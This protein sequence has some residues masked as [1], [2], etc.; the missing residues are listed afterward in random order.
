MTNDDVYMRQWLS[1]SMGAEGPSATRLASPHGRG[2]GLSIQIDRQARQNRVKLWQADHAA[3]QSDPL[4]ERLAGVTQ[5]F[6]G[7]GS[8]ATRLDHSHEVAAVAAVIAAELSLNVDL[9]AAI[10]LAHDCGH[11]PFGH[12]G[13]RELCN[14]VGSVN[15]ADWGA[16]LL[17][18]RGYSAEIVSG[19]RSHSWSSSTSCSTPEA[20]V[21]RWA[22]RICYLTRDFHDAVALGLLPQTALDSEISNIVG[23]CLDVQRKS[24]I[25][26]V[27]SASARTTRVSMEQ[28]EAVALAA[29]RRI[30]AVRIYQH[31]AVQQS[32]EHAQSLIAEAARMLRS[33]CSGGEWDAVVSELVTM[34]DVEVTM[35][36]LNRAP[37]QGKITVPS[38][39]G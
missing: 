36:V 39:L 30:N 27:V 25:S 1:T 2:A 12:A 23:D 34:T 35:L 21:V 24:L 26:G 20:E 16:D 32:N 19:V 15:H 10:G 14:L 9:A 31:P 28:D 8:Y 6:S 33:R 4:L 11:L 22:D 3:L 38:S 5:V 29:F 13:E 18:E 17:Q 37:D 7:H